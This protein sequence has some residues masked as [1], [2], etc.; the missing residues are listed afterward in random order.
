MASKCSCGCDA[1]QAPETQQ[2]QVVL[3]RLGFVVSKTPFCSE[4]YT[5]IAMIDEITIEEVQRLLGNIKGVRFDY[6]I[7]DEI[8]KYRVHCTVRI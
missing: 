5:V 1:L 6:D 7:F 8:T 3:D 4:R 2:L